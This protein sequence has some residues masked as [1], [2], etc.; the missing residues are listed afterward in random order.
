MSNLLKYPHLTIFITN[1]RWFKRYSDWVNA[2]IPY[3]LKR[4][5]V[6][7][8]SFLLSQIEDGL[9][10]TATGSMHLYHIF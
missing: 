9:K 8:Q 3:I 7:G 10:D 6:N 2:F 4:K 1:R 5:W